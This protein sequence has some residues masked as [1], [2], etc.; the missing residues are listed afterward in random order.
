MLLFLIS[1]TTLSFLNAMAI[2]FP[3][4]FTI[5]YKS[6]KERQLF[7]YAI[8]HTMQYK[9]DKKNSAT[10]GRVTCIG[11]LRKVQYCNIRKIKPLI[12]Q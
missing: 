3:L 11:A 1:L 2:S 12:V 7:R 4:L 8:I 10:I 5:A 9:T 6:N